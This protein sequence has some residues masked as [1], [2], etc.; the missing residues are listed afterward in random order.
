MALDALDPGPN[1]DFP[2]LPRLADGTLDPDRM[3][4]TPYYELTPYGRVLIDPTP[5]VTK[6]DGTRVRVTDIPPPAA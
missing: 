6:P 2:N 5:T 4:T 1:G 3:P